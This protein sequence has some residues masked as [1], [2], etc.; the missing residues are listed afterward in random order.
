M[1]SDA[2]LPP[3][4]F[5]EVL[6]PLPLRLCSDVATIDSLLWTHVFYMQRSLPSL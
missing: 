5:N 2:V 1:Y 3:N 6:Q 4:V